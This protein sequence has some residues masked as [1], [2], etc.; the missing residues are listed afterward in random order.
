[1]IDTDI[2]SRS[3]AVTLAGKLLGMAK[4]ITR[5]MGMKKSDLA[6]GLEALLDALEREVV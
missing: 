6:D 5:I 2:G 4:T 3:D 1:M